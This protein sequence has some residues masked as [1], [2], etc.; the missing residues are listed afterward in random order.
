MEAHARRRRGLLGAGAD[1]FTEA[2]GVALG[3]FKVMVPVVIA[4]KV[5]Q[6]LDLIRHLAWPL[7][8]VMGLVGLPA[9][10]GLVWATAMANNIYSGLI[11]LLALA[12]KTGL[13]A[14]Q[15]TVLGTMVLV[16]HGLPVELRIARAAGPRLLFQGALR[17]VGAF[18]LGWLLHVACQAFG[19]LQGPAN[20][21]ITAGGKT[22]E[23]GWTAWALGEVRNLASIFAIILAL[24][25]LMRVMRR[26]RATELLDW[27][28]R[29]VLRLM[30]VGSRASTITVIGLTMGLS[31]GGGLIIREARSGAVDRRDV[32]FSLSFM[33]LC[34]SL[35]ED[36]LL[37]AMAGGAFSGILW[38]R[39]IF[40]LV[41]IAAL[42]AVSRRLPQS[43]GDRWLW[44]PP[45]IKE[46]L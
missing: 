43:F 29:P 14:A 4:V 16:A 10:M 34:H 7:K 13:T 42:A 21:L 46:A 37:I 27:L 8:P 30:G 45:P 28:L 31:Y 35:V 26:I 15:A 9:E 41:A 32:F 11:V 20:I 22:A 18:V 19:A 17:V 39:L 1:I 33:G 5:L 6:E 3:L 40:S 25:A 2:A 23:P 38:G 24:V 44:G 36:T 12:E